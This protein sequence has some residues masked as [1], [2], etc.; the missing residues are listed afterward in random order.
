MLA[1]SPQPAIMDRSDE[2]P[3]EINGKGTPVNGINATMAE[4]LIN[5]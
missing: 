2:P 5:A 1:I 3:Y 4:K